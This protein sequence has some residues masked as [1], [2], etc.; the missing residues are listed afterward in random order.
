MNRLVTTLAL[1]ALVAS[2]ALAQSPNSSGRNK[3]PP[4][5]FS[6]H[7]GAYAQ[8]PPG[9]RGDRETAIRECNGAARSY[10]QHTYGHQEFDQYR[11]CMAQRGHME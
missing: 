9:E 6:Q 5:S 2:P 1:V 7:S 11:A 4:K 3:V 10:G 8:V